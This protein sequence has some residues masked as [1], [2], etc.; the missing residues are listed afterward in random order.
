MS[1]PLAKCAIDQ[2]Q[3]QI[4]PVNLGPSVIA[5]FAFSERVNH[6]CFA[7]FLFAKLSPVGEQQGQAFSRIEK[8][9]Q[10][11]AKNPAIFTNRAVVMAL[12][13]AQPPQ[14]EERLCPLLKQRLA[15][16]N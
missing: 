11:C 13:I 15:Q 16:V 7:T 4:A 14:S 5:F 3:F 10:V 6:A 9:V 1:S 2:I 8:S 12:V